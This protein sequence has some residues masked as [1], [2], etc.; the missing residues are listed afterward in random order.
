MF[1]FQG[2]EK[3]M[4]SKLAPLMYLWMIYILMVNHTPGIGWSQEIG[5]LGKD[6]DV[7][8]LHPGTVQRYN[9][10]IANGDAHG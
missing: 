10:T 5:A 6:G 8:N 1:Q 4:L 9:S 3:F 7:I 2:I